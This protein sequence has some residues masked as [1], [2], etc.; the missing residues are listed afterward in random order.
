[1]STAGLCGIPW[2][3]MGVGGDVIV[4]ATEG[5]GGACVGNCAGPVVAREGLGWLI[6]GVGGC[7]GSWGCWGNG[8]GRV[9]GC[10]ILSGMDCS[11]VVGTTGILIDGLTGATLAPEKAPLARL[12]STGRECFCGA[13]GA[14]PRA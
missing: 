4:P 11:I 5:C 7:W 14:G 8:V 10:E 9:G 13:A 6:N 3:C 2:G 12:L 1:M